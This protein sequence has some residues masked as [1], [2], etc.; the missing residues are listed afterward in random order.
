MSEDVVMDKVADF[1][2]G[3]GCQWLHLNP[4]SEVVDH[5]HEVG[6]ALGLFKE[7]LKKVQPP[8]RKRS[9][10]WNSLQCMHWLVHLLCVE[11][12]CPA[13]PYY[14]SGVLNLRRPVKTLMKGL[15]DHS[16]EGGAGAA[17][18]SVNLLQHEP[19]FLRGDTSSE[20][21]ESP[22]GDTVLL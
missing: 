2:G 8:G 16:S 19:S 7:R 15:I 12:A 9:S 4:R 6:V 18:T 13:P 21:P 14:V 3:D 10:E 11:L 1:G 17:Q 5:D 22:L 20:N